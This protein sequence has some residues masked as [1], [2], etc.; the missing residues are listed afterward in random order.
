MNQMQKIYIAVS[1][2]LVL[3]MFFGLDTKPSEQKLIEKSRANVFE[4]IDIGKLIRDTK[5][6]LT[7]SEQDYFSSLE[8]IAG[9]TTDDSSKIEVYQR[10]SSDWYRKGEG[11][12]AGHFAEKLA[13]IDNDAER[14]SIVGTTFGAALNQELEPRSGQYA[15]KKAI[16][17]FENA[18]SLDPDQLNHRLNRAILYAEHPQ[19]D[20]PMK[21]IQLLLELNRQNPESI[22]VLYHLARFGMQTGQYEKAIGRIEKGLLIDPENIKLI[23]LAAEAYKAI[24]DQEKYAIYN[25]FCTNKN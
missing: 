13:E 5:I 23:C 18:I 12:I 19:P 3:G 9:S 4:S 21:G 2:I 14:W 20:D 10:L 6:T 25:A 24:N 8:V 11:V 16:E 7:A 22:Q 17:A 1:I 15:F